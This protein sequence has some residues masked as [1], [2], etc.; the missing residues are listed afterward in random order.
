MYN[1]YASQQDDGHHGSTNL[2]M[3]ITD[4]VN[5][6]LWAAEKDGNAGYAL[7]HIFPASSSP[8]LRKF[9]R[10]VAGFTDPGDPIHS[11]SFYLTPGLLKRLADD[12]GVASYTIMQYP[13]QAVYIP[14]GC[15]HQ[16]CCP[17]SFGW[18]CLDE[19]TPIHR[20]A[21]PRMP[22]KPPVISFPSTTSM[23]ANI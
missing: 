18:R 9:L 22:L 23:K 13:G 21:T 17:Y 20:L 3:D 15:A 11:Q 6:M 14:A 2:H 8:T 16:V 19:L 1:A 10:D 5:I 12:Y 7:W 4:A